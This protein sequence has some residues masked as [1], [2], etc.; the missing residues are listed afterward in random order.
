MPWSRWPWLSGLCIMIEGRIKLAQM[1]YN[2]PTSFSRYKH[3]KKD[4]VG[5]LDDGQPRARRVGPYG[6]VLAC[7]PLPHI[8]HPYNPLCR[9][10][11]PPSGPGHR[12]FCPL[13]PLW[14]GLD[15]TC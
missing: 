7:G 11:D 9:T 14:T 3:R 15:D 6:K 13:P 2:I 1:T 12:G 4:K 10:G 8:Q 5:K